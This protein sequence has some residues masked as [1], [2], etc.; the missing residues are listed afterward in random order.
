MTDLL[1]YSTPLG[2]F[3]VGTSIASMFAAAYFWLRLL[4]ATMPEED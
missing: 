3:L 4:N 2:C 1:T